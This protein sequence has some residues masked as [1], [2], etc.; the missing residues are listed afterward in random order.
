MS[1]EAAIGLHAE[2]GG[3]YSNAPHAKKLEEIL[4]ADV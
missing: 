1:S 4:C 2:V 3:G